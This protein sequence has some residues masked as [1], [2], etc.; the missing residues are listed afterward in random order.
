MTFKVGII[1]I[2]ILQVRHL[3]LRAVNNS[4]RVR[5][6][7]TIKHQQLST[8]PGLLPTAAPCIA[9]SR[10]VQHERSC[11][12]R[13]AV[14]LSSFLPHLLGDTRGWR[15]CKPSVEGGQDCTG[16]VPGHCGPDR[17]PSDAVQAETPASPLTSCQWP[18]AAPAVDGET[19][20]VHR[21]WHTVLHRNT[22]SSCKREMGDF[23][24]VAF[25]WI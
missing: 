24:L 5:Q 14:A 9:D 2:P 7:V 8:S 1:V 10:P 22:H 17:L 16:V 21:P 13:A 15:V 4:Y 23:L 6:L 20:K 12:V 25:L 3:G 18:S 11:R 19:A